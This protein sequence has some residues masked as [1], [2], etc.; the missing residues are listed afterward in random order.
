MK[1]KCMNSVVKFG[2]KSILVFCFVQLGLWL[3]LHSQ[4]SSPF[5]L[6]VT[7]HQKDVV[8]FQDGHWRFVFD[9]DHKAFAISDSAN[10]PYQFATLQDER[11][12]VL[13][14]TGEWRFLEGEQSKQKI[15]TTSPQEGI[16]STCR[17]CSKYPKSNNHIAPEGICSPCGR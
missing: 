9:D 1:P 10:D 3:G 6:A 7:E 17:Q 8:L 2:R 4:N 16:C 15:T 11:R 12:V 13:N 5:E 14:S